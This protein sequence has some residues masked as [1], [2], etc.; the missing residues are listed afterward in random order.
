MFI[1]PSNHILLFYLLTNS[2]RCCLLVSLLHLGGG[3]PQKGTWRNIRGRWAKL[4]TGAEPSATP[5]D[6]PGF[7]LHAAFFFFIA[8]LPRHKLTSVWARGGEELP[9]LSQPAQPL[10]GRRLSSSASS[11]RHVCQCV[12]VRRS[13]G[14]QISRL[15]LEKRWRAPQLYERLEINWFQKWQGVFKKKCGKNIQPFLQSSA[16]TS[17]VLKLAPPPFAYS[18]SHPQRAWIPEPANAAHLFWQ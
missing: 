14:L 4:K 18:C 1:L 8:A 2:K 10:S 15:P 13:A 9:L 16:G 3:G 7:D 12:C 17:A 11:L 5:A 6:R